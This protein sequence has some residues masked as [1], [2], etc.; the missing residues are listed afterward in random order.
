MIENVDFSRFSDRNMCSAL[1]FEVLYRV[2]NTP[3]KAV[4]R[5]LLFRS[6]LALSAGQVRES[7]VSATV[8]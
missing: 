6:F 8:S 5:A 1:I 3:Q 2:E 7:S 4:A